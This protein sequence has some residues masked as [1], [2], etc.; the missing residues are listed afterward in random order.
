MVTASSAPQCGHCSRGP[1]QQV[2]EPRPGGALS[3]DS[4]DSGR[5]NLDDLDAFLAVVDGGGVSPAARR[6]GVPKSTVSRRLARLERHL[7]VP[8][9]YRSSRRLGLTEAGHDLVERAR[10]L[11]ADSDVLVA[12]AAGV[13]IEPRGTLR[14][15]APIE[16]S[17]HAAMWASFAV[18]HPR[19]GLTVSFSNRRVDVLGEGFDLALRGRP[20][21]DPELVARRVGTYALRAVATPTWVAAQG[22]ADALRTADLRHLD[23]VLLAPVEPLDAPS[24]HHARDR[25][26][27]HTILGDLHVVRA[28]VLRG[29]GVGVLPVELVASDL[30][31][32]RLVSVLDAYDPVEVPLYAVYRDRRFLPASVVALI[33]HV[34]AALR[35]VP[36]GE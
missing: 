6:L 17:A 4:Q 22:P 2:A 26:V 23:A 25:P 24:P 20:G 36:R 18:D 14:V 28:A 35:R 8:L 5:P 12:R 30:A 27:R 34:Q 32:G 16:L 10:R 3:G 33:G 15:S 31:E 1:I 11:L 29:A 21:D 13:P 19:V 9:V 7:G